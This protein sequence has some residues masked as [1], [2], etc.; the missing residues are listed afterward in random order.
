MRRSTVYVDARLE[1]A[2]RRLLSAGQVEVDF[3]LAEE[4]LHLVAG[5]LRRVANRQTPAADPPMPADCRL[6]ERARAAIHDDHPAARVLCP[7]A[8]LLSASPY[9]LSR[10]FPKELGVSVTRYR[11]RVRVGR[12]L[13]QLQRDTAP[14][15]DIANSLG[16]ADQ[17]DFSRV[18][19]EH[20]GHTPAA[21]RR[22]LQ[23]AEVA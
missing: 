3:W 5:A 14:L 19:R 4:L 21:L 11:N 10:A 9:R 16:F 6:V 8:E 2:H 22:A 18:V 23:T 17:A 15:A 1:L 12:A 13:K 20:V 7:L